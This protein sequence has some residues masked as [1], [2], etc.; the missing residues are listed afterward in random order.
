MERVGQEKVALEPSPGTGLEPDDADIHHQGEDEEPEGD[1]GNVQRW[2]A[3]HEAGH[4][5]A[6]ELEDR[7]RQEQGDEQ[8]TERLELGMAIWVILVGCLGGHAHHENTEDVA[9]RVDG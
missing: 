5:P 9:G 2:G 7:E 3:R 4:G 8:G 6:D 1:A